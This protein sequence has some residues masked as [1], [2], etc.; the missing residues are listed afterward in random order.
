MV[1]EFSEPLVGD[2]LV[3]FKEAETDGSRLGWGSGLVIVAVGLAVA[4]VA[5]YFLL[6]RARPVK[7]RSS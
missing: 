7:T 1:S 2:L 5:G 4:G 3:S 6:K